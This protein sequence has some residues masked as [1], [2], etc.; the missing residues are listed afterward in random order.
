M[1]ASAASSAVDEE[2]F[3]DLATEDG[4]GKEAASV[5]SK[6]SASLEH[7]PYFEDLSNHLKIGIIGPTNVGKS[8]LF[9]ILTRSPTTYS[10]VDNALFTTVDPFVATFTPRDERMEFFHKCNPSAA[11]KPSRLTIIDTAGLVPNAVRDVS[12]RNFARRAA[13]LR[14]NC[15]VCRAPPHQR[16]GVGAQSLEAIQYADALLVLLKCFDSSEL[17][18]Y[19]PVHDPLRDL[20]MVELEL[21]QLVSRCPAPRTAPRALDATSRLSNPNDAWYRT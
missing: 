13:V 10:M 15:N 7:R 6:A 11:L 19:D 5:T 8:S 1:T 17:A 18:R 2:D 14:C 21:L 12:M 4:E 16:Q 9:N 3:G 20:K